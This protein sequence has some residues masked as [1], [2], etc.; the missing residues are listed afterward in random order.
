MEN[1]GLSNDEKPQESEK[2]KITRRTFLIAAGT[3][4]AA[5]A[6][7][8]IVTSAGVAAALRPRVGEGVVAAKIP[9]SEMPNAGVIRHNPDKC[10]ACGNCVA[11]CS[12]YHE[13]SASIAQAR[14]NVVTDYYLS[15][16]RAVT[17]CHQCSSPSCY[18][19]CPTDAMGIDL[20]RGARYIDQSKCLGCNRCVDACPYMPQEAI[21]KRKS[22]E[23]EGY[24][25]FKCDLCYEREEG[26]ACVEFCPYGALE[27]VSAEERGQV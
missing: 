15:G 23:P 20:N 7:S 24:V 1:F 26:P 2:R 8:G 14:L 22:A 27:Y 21:I 4:A 18:Y 13:G 12:T 11:R 17:T 16:E 3:G 19:A 6:A 5:G 9:P 10:I 25:Y